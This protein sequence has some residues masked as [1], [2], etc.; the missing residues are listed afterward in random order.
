MRGRL[1]FACVL[2]VL[3]AATW[4]AMPLAAERGQ[5]AAEPVAMPAQH[6]TSTA[7]VPLASGWNLIS[8][9]LTPSS[10][11]VATALNSIAGSYTLVYA[12]DSLDGDSPW[13]HYSPSTPGYANSLSSV[14]ERQG[15]WVLMGEPGTLAVSGSAPASTSIPLVAGWNL[16]GYTLQR[17]LPV[18]EALASIAGLYDQVWAYDAFAASPWMSF[19]PGQAPCGCNLNTMYGGAGYWIHATQDCTLVYGPA[20]CTTIQ[21]GTF[22]TVADAYVW[23]AS[24]DYTGNWENLYTGMV[25]GG[26]KR[27]LVRFDLAAIPSNARV[28]SAT[29]SI[30][31]YSAD[32]AH[33]VTVHRITQTWDENSVTWLTFGNAFDVSVS[34]SYA[35][36][37]TGWR[38]ADVT[39]LVQSWVAGSAANF[40]LLLNDPSPIGSGTYYSSEYGEVALRPK[41]LVCYY[42]GSWPTA[43]P[44]PTP[45]RTRTAAPSATRTATPTRTSTP[46]GPTATATATRTRTPMPTV[47]RTPTRTATPGPTPSRQAIIIDHTCT[48][49]GLIPDNWL[50]QAKALTIHYGHTSHGS[51]LETGALYL[52]EHINSK[53]AIAI[54]YGNATPMPAPSGELRMYDGNN[55]GDDTYIV[56]EMYWA[57]TDGLNHTRSVA[58]TGLFQYSMWAW[59]GQQSENSVETVQ[60]YLD[61]LNGLEAQYPN[62]RF[63]YMTGHTDGGS[64]TLARNNQMVR[65]Y[66]RTHNKV[67]FD[68]ADIESWD[69]AGNNYPST[70][71]ACGWCATW[72]AQHPSD[73]L[74]LPSTD[75]DCAHS[76]GFNCKLKGQAFWWMM[77]R[78]AGWPGP[79]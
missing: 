72:C 14:N 40:G 51:Q 75:G 53:Y 69:P 74:N 46:G 70:T 2:V 4:R 56:P 60:A 22:G 48:N 28:Q 55:Y 16:V 41:L 45:T 24:P 13:R 35:T 32:A 33:T 9:P 39:T 62:M 78:L 52:E 26:T 64:T 8:L 44:S 36:N 66:C 21:R 5:P 20:P 12:F 25:D 10:S 61:A 63:I 73:C 37:A 3:M 57:A 27:S 11:D 68:F 67:L 7:S 54:Y 29:L 47:T 77:A 50:T 43:T 17:S 59:C 23:A 65:D 1:P 76:H 19:Y 30:Y 31:L 6:I 71:D 79:G 49:I 58:N 42:G 15:L 18:T 38:T 34:G